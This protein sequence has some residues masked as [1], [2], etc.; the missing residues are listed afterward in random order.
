MKDQWTA[1][2]EDFLHILN[3]PV[4]KRT[5]EKTIHHHPD[6]PGLLV[7]SEALRLWGVENEAIRVTLD[8]MTDADFPCIALMNGNRCVILKKIQGGEVYLKHPGKKPI[9]MTS[10]EFIDN[11][12]GIALIASPV[13]GAGERNYRAELWK[14]RLLRLRNVLVPVLLVVLSVLV[15][16]PALRGETLLPGL[17]PVLAVKTIG[18]I[19]CI[20]LY[21]VSIG[22]GK[23]A[24]Q[25]CPTHGKIN[26]HGVISSPAGKILGIPMTD[27]GLLYFSGGLFSIF[28]AAYFGELHST[29]IA[30]A[31]LNVMT[32]PYTLFSVAYQGI[33][34]KTWCWLCLT[35][36]AVFWVEFGF[37]HS[38][39]GEGVLDLPANP[40]LA[41]IPGF[42][43]PLSIWLF[44]RQLLG[45]SRVLEM[46]ERELMRLRRNPKVIES[47]LIS[48]DKMDMQQE[49]PEIKFGPEDASVTLTL[50]LTFDCG[51]CRTIFQETRRLMDKYPVLNARVRLL[52]D[53][54]LLDDIDRE[55]YHNYRV[56]RTMMELLLAG[57]RVE[58]V[59]VLDDWFLPSRR[60]TKKEID[61]WLQPFQESC[62][63]N[64]EAADRILRHYH[65]W[66]KMNN[67]TDTP[68]TLLNGT[69]LPIEIRLADLEYY[70]MRQE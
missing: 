11:W 28:F 24:R 69:K 17:I 12:T 42:L 34:L 19:A 16:V 46:H 61:Q 60:K 9:S 18:L 20:L 31:L 44:L 54:K 45:N 23:V 56:A 30:L 13:P 14:E 62:N 48:S 25:V 36:Q 66:T 68:T 51:Y 63:G 53:S 41:V 3:V 27:L 8:Q 37:L 2:T 21:F 1:L 59:Q 29:F 50:I 65:D 57:K 52:L 7:V 38:F 32:L 10:E 43:F 40:P 70:F 49:F 47:L 5:I 33:V 4:T 39:L 64:Q 58:A 15:M 55:K 22:F 35:V 6:T 26:C 67:I